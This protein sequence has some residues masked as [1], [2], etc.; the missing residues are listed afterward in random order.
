M[1]DFR[2]IM[3]LTVPALL[4]GCGG[5][6][7]PESNAGAD[8]LGMTSGHSEQ[9][10]AID[11]A[12]QDAQAATAAAGNMDP[13]ASLGDATAEEALTSYLTACA[14]G[15]LIRAAEFCHP[16][17]PGTQKLISTGEG[18][19]RASADPSVAGM[20]IRG[21]LTQGLDQATHALLE[22]GD[23]RFAFEVTVPG[24]APTRI[25]V[26]LLDGTWKV[27]PPDASGLPVS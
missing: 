4:I 17:A 9:S 8:T 18:F 27:I 6:S 15:E 1:R 12:R 7:E 24:K 21:W 13:L 11:Q 10:A 5:S 16:D 23:D 3:M 26:T 19:E 20:D 25:E 2:S 22:E 14:A